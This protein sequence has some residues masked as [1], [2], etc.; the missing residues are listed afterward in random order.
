MTAVR[1]IF[2]VMK[3]DLITYHIETLIILKMQVL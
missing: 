2:T 1:P 3:Q